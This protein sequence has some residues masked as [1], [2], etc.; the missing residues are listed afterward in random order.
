MVTGQKGVLYDSG[1]FIIRLYF[2]YNPFIS[3]LTIENDTAKTWRCWQTKEP[4]HCLPGT[5]G[6][7]G[8]KPALQ[9]YHDTSIKT[10]LVAVV[11]IFITAAACD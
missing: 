11:F 5:H 3:I 8:L 7:S 9:E 10:S 4:R 2:F 6:V 1:P